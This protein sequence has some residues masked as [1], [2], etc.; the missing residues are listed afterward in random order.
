MTELDEI[1]RC[2]EK[3]KELISEKVDESSVMNILDKRR[4][5][6]SRRRESH[7]EREVQ[8]DVIVSRSGDA[9]LGFPVEFV[10][11]VHKNYAI[12]LA[13]GTDIVVGLFQ[14]RG[15][16]YALVDILP[17]LGQTAA[18]R[19]ALGSGFIVLLSYEKREIG[20]VVDELAGRR[21]IYQDE[22]A[23]GHDEDNSG[24]IA[25]ISK[26]LVSIIEMKA[27]F[28]SPQIVLGHGS[29]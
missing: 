11:E 16:V 12:P 14:S 24:I 27:L 17:L 3:L 2:N 10:K 22:I 1:R 29:Q 26:D 18:G 28:A 5:M 7:A 8:A 23:R 9:M 6:M 15:Q 25:S 4:E 21:I 20:V 13:H 19:T